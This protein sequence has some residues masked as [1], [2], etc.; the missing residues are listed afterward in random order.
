VALINSVA[1]L[2][3]LL[4]PSLLG[5]FGLPAMAVVLF[6]AGALALCA[7]HDPTLDRRYGPMTKSQ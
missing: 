3:G 1:N 4:G 2:G 6:A 7:R 5:Q